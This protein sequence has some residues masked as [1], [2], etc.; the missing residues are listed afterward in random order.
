MPEDI[1]MVLENISKRYHKNDAFVLKDVSL[2]VKKAEFIALLG[3]SGSGK[4]TLLHIAG[5]L[6]MPTSGSIFVE[7]KNI[8]KAT[9]DEK[10][11][12]RLLKIG[13]IYQY[14]HLLQEFSAIENV[15]L[16]QL[17]R[18]V[19][20]KSAREKAASLLSDMKLKDKPNSF[21]S[22]LSGGQKQ[23][24]AIARALANDPLILL[25]DEPTGNLDPETAFLVLDDLMQIVRSTGMS[26]IMGTH[27]YELAEKMDREFLISEGRLLGK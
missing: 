9:D 5:L 6:D 18:G 16:P 12:L 17:I 10:T 2:S 23:R 11:S 25:A 3:P 21:P 27:N 1:V 13:F 7:G 15:M 19:S 22:E 8:Q 14:H 24:V 4:S 20:K 26:I